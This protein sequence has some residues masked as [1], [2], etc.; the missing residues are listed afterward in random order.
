M[1]SWSCHFGFIVCFIVFSGFVL[2]L[3]LFQCSVFS[4]VFLWSSSVCFPSLASPSSQCSQLFQPVSPVPVSSV[5][6]LT[7]VSPPHSTC[8]SSPPQF[9]LYLSLCSPCCLCQFILCDSPVLSIS[10][11]S[12]VYPDLNLLLIILLLGFLVFGLFPFF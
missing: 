1:P 9:W 12:C 11:C 5:F 4:T 8:T 3:A 10:D 2:S 7:C 6:A